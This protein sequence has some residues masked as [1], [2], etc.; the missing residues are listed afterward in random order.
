MV[1][2]IAVLVAAAVDGW[3]VQQMRKKMKSVVAP[4]AAD[5]YSGG[6]AH[7]EILKHGSSYPSRLTNSMVYQG[8]IIIP[9]IFELEVD[10]TPADFLGA[11]LELVAGYIF[12]HFR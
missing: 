5:R 2:E 4:A 6:G 12:R 1:C 9:L 3:R 11:L 10:G 7:L 8:L